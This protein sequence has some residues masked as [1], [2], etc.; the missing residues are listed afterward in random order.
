[1]NNI[2]NNPNPV[3]HDNRAIVAA[4]V[5]NFALDADRIVNLIAMARLIDQNHQ[6]NQSPQ[7]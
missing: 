5:A 6:E 7:A 2:N 1:M 3:N 4:N